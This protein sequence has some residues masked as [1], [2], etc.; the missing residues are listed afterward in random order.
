MMKELT[1][2]KHEIQRLAFS[3]YLNVHQHDVEC[4]FNISCEEIKNVFPTAREWKSV[5]IILEYVMNNSDY[6]LLNL[7]ENRSYLF[8]V[9]VK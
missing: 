8:A 9:F 3:E 5:K 1:E 2:H 7:Y 6:T 4:K